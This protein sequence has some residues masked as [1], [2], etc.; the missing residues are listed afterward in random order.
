ME[1]LIDRIFLDELKTLMGPKFSG[2][3]TS[4][5]TRSTGHAQAVT[6]ILADG[7]RPDYQALADHAHALKSIAGQIGAVAVAEV[8]SGMEEEALQDEPSFERLALAASRLD[9]ILP[10]TQKALAQDA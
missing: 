4:F 10:L 2:V 6:A 8:A 3:E 1:E 9:R 5:R 7:D